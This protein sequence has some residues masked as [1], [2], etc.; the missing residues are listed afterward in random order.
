[1]QLAFASQAKCVLTALSLKTAYTRI[2]MLQNMGGKPIAASW[3]KVPGQQ[4]P[5]GFLL[6]WVFV[7]K[8][9]QE[10]NQ[11]EVLEGVTRILNE[12]TLQSSEETS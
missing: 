12:P 3:R 9:V 7:D 1:M 10:S 11:R 4:I 2:N 6:L 5:T 8:S